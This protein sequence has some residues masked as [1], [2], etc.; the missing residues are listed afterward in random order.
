[1]LPDDDRFYF[2][3]MQS[4]TLFCVGSSG[5]RF[6]S[7]PC[8]RAMLRRPSKWLVK[9]PEEGCSSTAFGR[10]SPVPGKGWSNHADRG[11]LPGTGD[12]RPAVP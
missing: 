5:L 12:F 1:M 3:F 6:S 9:R 4:G 2:A 7:L 10:K 8:S 11:F